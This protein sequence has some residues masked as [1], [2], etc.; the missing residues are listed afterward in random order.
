[1]SFEQTSGGAQS[2][3]LELEQQRRKLETLGRLAGNVVHDFNNLL[4][5]IEGYTRMLLEEPN[6]TGSGQES[7]QEIL[8]AAERASALTRQLLAFSRKTG[9]EGRAV[10]VNSQLRQMRAMLTRLLG[11][12]VKLEYVLAEEPCVIFANSAQLEQLLLNLI[13]NARDAVPIGGRIKVRTETDSGHVRIIVEDNGVGIPEELLPR[14]FE[15]F[16]TTKEHGKGTGIGLA[17]VRETVQEWKG[18]IDVTSQ[19]REGTQFLIELPRYHDPAPAPVAAPPK[20][21]VIEGTILLVED[22][23]GVR[24]LIRRVLEQRHYRV[25]ESSTEQGAL[26]LARLEKD[27]D[28]LITDLELK[29]GEGRR[30]AE[31][32]KHLHPKAKVVL[33]SGYVTEADGSADLV[34][35]KP[36]SPNTMVLAVQHLLKSSE[37]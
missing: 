23:D 2:E 37:P 24:A 7:A 35:Q 12:S 32:V 5:V 33:I 27:I 25:L 19:L 8:R 20:P 26:D 3:N 17:L 13:V 36:F 11:E 22:E 28:L 30:L 15:P 18:R 16:F 21:A 34:L 9:V 4:M 29:R 31:T 14:I 1:M 10:E 6:L